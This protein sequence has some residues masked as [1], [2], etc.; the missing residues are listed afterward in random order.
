MKHNKDEVI[1]LKDV[2]YS[3]KLLYAP[4]HKRQGPA[5]KYKITITR[6]QI[7]DIWERT[8][9]VILFSQEM[10]KHKVYEAD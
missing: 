9:D 10:E 1:R 6:K 4:E 3:G 7:N 8:K 2:F 5:K